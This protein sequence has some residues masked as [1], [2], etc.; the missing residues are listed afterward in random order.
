MTYQ[1]YV[2][3]PRHLDEWCRNCFGEPVRFPRHSAQNAIIRTFLQKTPAGK[4]PDLGEPGQTAIALP[5]SSGKPVEVFNYMSEAGKRAVVESV[6]DLF[7]RALWSDLSPL[8]QPRIRLTVL[9]EAWCDRNGISPE[10]VEAVRQTYYRLRKEM[11]ARG[12]NLR[13]RQMVE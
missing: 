5:D 1:I 12:V 8:Q 3:L 6:R 13:H 11:A 10:S 9:I 4:L 2:T 7:L